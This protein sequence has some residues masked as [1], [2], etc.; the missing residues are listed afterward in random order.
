MNYKQ[1]LEYVYSLESFGIKLGLDRIRFLLRKFGNPEKKMRIIH[2][3]GTNGKGSVCAMLG[4]VLREKYDVGVYTSPHL[5]DIRER[6]T[7]NGRMISKNDFSRIMTEIK[8]INVPSCFGHPTFFETLTAVALKYFHEKKVDFAVVEVGLGG[9]L[10]ATNIVKPL[11]SVITNVSM[12][13]EDVLGN[14]LEKIAGEK[15]GIIKKN[16]PVVTSAKSK[17][18]LAVI[19]R[20][21]REKGCRLINAGEN[22][23]IRKIGHN[24]D[25]Q[26]FNLQT[27]K[28][29]Y[30]N[31]RIPF[32]G[33][34]QLVNAATALS[35]I[36]LLG[37]FSEM[38]VRNGFSKT[39]W[40][41]RLEIINKNPLIVVDGAHNPDCMRKLK[42]A[43]IE[44]FN[45]D[46]LILVLGILSDK[47]IKKMVKIIAPP[48]DI[49]VITKPDTVRAADPEIIKNEAEKYIRTVVVK[50]NVKNALDYAKS[51][52]NKNDMILVTGSLYTVGDV[53]R[54]IN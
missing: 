14:T 32:L 25:G 30:F 40:P 51:I 31:L 9:R 10:D 29:K 36:E 26:F 52:A 24:L 17:K 54:V 50:D 33:K 5:V 21:C 43:V 47:N 19:K 6:I 22:V 16:V 45:Y 3:A 37:G 23:K 41:G 12:E 46:K 13:H 15:A 34:H 53:K 38:D 27:K 48:S 35:V 28:N 39:K 1:S 44:Y 49:V 8:K 20:I 2:V 4:S 18:V 11:F 42:P 7:I